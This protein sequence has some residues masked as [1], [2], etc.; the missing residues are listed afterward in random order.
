VTEE[1]RAQLKRY[2]T[3]AADAQ[4]RVAQSNPAEATILIQLAANWTALAD[5]VEAEIT[6]IT[7]GL[8]G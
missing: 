6:K 8:T 5:M 3:Y 7:G 2:R 4:S 1:L